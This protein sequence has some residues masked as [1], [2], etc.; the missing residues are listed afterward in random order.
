MEISKLN[1]FIIDL[2]KVEVNTP[3]PYIGRDTS[4]SRH[5][6]PEIFNHAEYKYGAEIGVGKGLNSQ[7]WCQQMPDLR[8]ICIDPYTPTEFYSFSQRR[9]DSYFEQAQKNLAGYNVTFMRQFSIDAVKEFKDGELDFVYIDAAHDFDN[10]M[11]D[12]IHWAPK[13]RAGGIVAGHDYFYWPGF[14][15][16]GAVNAYTLAHRINPWFLTH[17]APSRIAIHSW[18]WVVTVKDH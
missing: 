15:V 2:L 9:H 12:V 17:D 16:I 10:A 18:F 13:V 8:L 1:S 3:L 6:L 14:N 7:S 4:F 5:R 11:I